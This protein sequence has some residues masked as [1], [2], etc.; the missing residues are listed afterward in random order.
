MDTQTGRAEPTG[1]SE[2]ARLDSWKQI[3]AYLEKSER[4]VRRWQQ[5]EGLP[6]HRQLHQQRGSVWAYRKELDEW[7]AGRTSDPQPLPDA[8]PA[9]RPFGSLVAI[10]LLAAA[11]A[12]GVLWQIRKPSGALVLDPVQMTALA[13]AAYNPAFSPDGKRLAF[14]WSSASELNAGIYVKS[15]GSETLAPIFIV[16]RD[17]LVFPYAPAW[18]PDGKTIAFLMRVSR[19]P[20][21]TMYATSSE[22]WLCLIASSG[23]PERK[24]IRLASDVIYYAN[25]AHLSWSPDGQWIVAPMADQDRKGIFRIS[26]ASGEA[27]RITTAALKEFAPMLSPNGRA[28][29]FMRQEGP[30]AASIEQVVRQDLTEDGTPH[31]P[32]RILYEGRSM[33]SGLAWL[34]SGKELIFCTASSAYFGPFNSRLHRM[35]SEARGPMEPLGISG[36]SGI[37]IS[38]PDGSGNAMLIYAGGENTKG[39]LRQAAL[40]DLGNSRPFAPSSRFDGFPS[41]SPDGSLVAF[42]SNRS[43]SPEVWIA[44]QDGTSPRSLTEGSNVT[45]IP[46]WSPDGAHL[47]FGAAAAPDRKMAHSELYGIYIVPIAGGSPVRIGLTP[48]WV[49]DPSWSPDGKW[50]YF[51]S[52]SE[53]WRARPDGSE[54]GRIGEYPADFVR[55]GISDGSYMY[56]TK[57]SKPFALCRV[58][59]GN[60]DEEVLAEGLSTAFVAMT[61]R[62][63]YFFSLADSSL[64]A[65]PLTGGA[66]HRIGVLPKFEGLRRIILGIS[67][68]PDDKSIVW[69]VSEKQQLDLHV[70]Y[71]IR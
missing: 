71:N 37:A 21:F 63:V 67:V 69:A 33:S 68:S 16:K 3:A 66:P 30:A 5:T 7:L 38:R 49:A 14:F 18:S 32:S 53:L 48:K 19:I 25:S 55:A 10:A 41:Y 40:G 42:V 59:I 36:C 29:V 52:G 46:R 62:F 54:A 15:I 27:R 6:V 60:G 39:T 31:G 58:P 64:N 43:G 56:Y 44:K 22:T 8:P 4:T 34:P 50:I 12:A 1:T 20:G 17:G 51:W 45:S 11:V 2:P 23:G 35:S 61:R 9:K 13:G 65:L 28:V 26:T 57:P 70:V 47:A 24:L